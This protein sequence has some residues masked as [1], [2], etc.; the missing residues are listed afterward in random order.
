MRRTTVGLL[1]VALS[2]S[3][4]ASTKRL[5]DDELDHYNALRVWM[6]DKEKKAY[7]RLKERT[8][9]DAWLKARGYWDKWYQF[10]KETREKMLNGEVELGFSQDQVFMTWGPAFRRKRLTGRFAARS[11]LLVYRFEVANDGSIMVWE[12]KSKATYKA[13]GKYQLELYID[14]LEVVEIQKKDEWE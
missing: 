12:P 9:R 8:E 11:E 4:G 14:D 5:D 13:S 10:D 1:L 3:I 7:L 2:L 6:N